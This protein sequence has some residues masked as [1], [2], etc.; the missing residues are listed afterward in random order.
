MRCY[1]FGDRPVECL[2]RVFQ[3]GFGAREERYGVV[4]SGEELGNGEADAAAA[5]YD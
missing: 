1:G 4:V 3:R 5:A 2:E